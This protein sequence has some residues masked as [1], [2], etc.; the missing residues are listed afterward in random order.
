MDLGLFY[1]DLRDFAGF[2]FKATDAQVLAIVTK[3]ADAGR[4][5]YS[6]VAQLEAD[7]RGIRD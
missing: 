5:T 4:L 6:R 3:E 1:D 7:R 2:C